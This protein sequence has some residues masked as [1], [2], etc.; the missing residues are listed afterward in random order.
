M[1]AKPARLGPPITG[2]TGP[3][4][5]KDLL[6]S[7]LP[8][9][10]IPARLK[11]Y[12][13]IKSW[14]VCVG[15]VVARKAAPERLVEGILHCSVVSPP[16]ITEL[17]YQKREIAA[18]LNRELG[19]PVVKDI[20]FRLGNVTPSILP[21]KRPVRPVQELSGAELIEIEQT[22]SVIK[23]D[24]LREAVKRAMIRAKAEDG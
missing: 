10:G 22:A 6:A 12:S 8:H 9:L 7:S 5:I 4:V 11:E 15:E 23:D 14:P 3:A 20:I 24:E 16:W 17:T 19:G 1:R 18:R 21:A 13:I 2:K